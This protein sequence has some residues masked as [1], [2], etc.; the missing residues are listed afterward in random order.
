MKEFK[1]PN[2]FWDF[3]ELIKLYVF[4][5]HIGPIVVVYIQIQ[6]ALRNLPVFCEIKIKGKVTAKKTWNATSFSLFE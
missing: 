1:R 4:S 2:F 6:H 3:C 5:A